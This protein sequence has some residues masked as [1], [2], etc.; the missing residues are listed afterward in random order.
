MLAAPTGIFAQMSQPAVLLPKAGAPLTLAVGQQEIRV[1]LVADGLVA[2]W[3]IVFIPGTSDLLVTESNG[4]LRLIADG[5]LVAEPVWTSPSPQGNDVLHG[6]VVHPK[7]ET[8]RFVYLSYLKGDDTS[9]TLAIS[10]LA[11]RLDQ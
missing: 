3:D 2:P 7:F 1:V 10:R 11:S 8:N 9:Q 4:A 6:V 5:K